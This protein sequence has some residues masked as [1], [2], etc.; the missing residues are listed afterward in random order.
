VCTVLVFATLQGE[1]AGVGLSKMAEVLRFLSGQASSRDN[2]GIGFEKGVSQD[3][4][5]VLYRRKSH[6]GGRFPRHADEN[7]AEKP[8]SIQ[9]STGNLQVR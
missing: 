6:E 2:S 1:G 8:F 9:S 4:P 5:F 3:I 7:C